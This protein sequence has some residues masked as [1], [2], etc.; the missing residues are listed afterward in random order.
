MSIE[1]YSECRIKFTPANGPDKGHNHFDRCLV[2]L[3]QYDMGDY[4]LK[5]IDLKNRKSEIFHC[6]LIRRDQYIFASSVEQPDS[7]NANGGTYQL[8][9]NDKSRGRFHEILQ[10]CLN[11][12]ITLKDKDACPALSRLDQQKSKAVLDELSNQV[13]KPYYQNIDEFECITCYEKIAQGEGMSFRGCLHP[14]CKQCLL[15]I[16]ETSTEPLLKCPHDDC[17]ML[18]D[19]RELRGVRVVQNQ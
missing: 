12:F 4:A 18:I 15:K 9:L 2:E 14:L 7:I 16:I 10:I 3:R 17:T 19:E 5:V 13:N 11:E 6:P 1:V 8:W